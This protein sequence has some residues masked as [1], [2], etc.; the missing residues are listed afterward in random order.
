MEIFT[1][2]EQRRAIK[3]Y[4][5]RV[6]MS[7]TEFRQM[8]DAVLCSPTSYNIQ[9]WR[10][11][12]VRDRQLRLQLKEAAWGQQQVEDASEIIIVCGDTQAW[13]DRPH[14]YWANADEAT[15]SV[16]L[17]MIKDFYLGK[18]Q[19]Q[20]DEVMRS[21]G[22]AAQTLMLSAKALGYDSCPMIGFDM[23][24]V[25]NIIQLPEGHVVC[26]MVAIGKATKEANP[27]G[28]QLALSDVLRENTF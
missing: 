24:T 3:H 25:S 19:T 6:Q 8:M 27:R 16:L 28:G 5:S 13:S 7:D 23:E 26:M 12:R 20:R 9:H 22:M 17:P 21:A 18:E 2:I 11:V 14:R 15:Q 4:D 1:A 10:F